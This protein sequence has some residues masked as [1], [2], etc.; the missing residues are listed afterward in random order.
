MSALKTNIIILLGC[1][2]SGILECSEP[3]ERTLNVT[4]PP[5]IVKGE[6]E[7]VMQVME[8]HLKQYEDLQELR[9]QKSQNLIKRLRAKLS[10]TLP[11]LDKL[12]P[13]TNSAS[14]T[15]QSSSTQQH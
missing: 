4:V 7:H 9:T 15:T 11:N 13:I 1:L 8:Q 10:P 14:S 2:L 5:I 12:L 3:N 6:A